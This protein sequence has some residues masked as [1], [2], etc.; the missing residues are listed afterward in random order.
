MEIALRHL[1]G[2]R[3]GDLVELLEYAIKRPD[4]RSGKILAP[5]TSSTSTLAEWTPLE[6]AQA[7]WR[8][9]EEGIADPQVSAGAHD[10]VR[11]VLQAAFRLPDDDVREA[12]GSSL[13]ERFKQLRVLRSVFGE[14]TTTQPMEI[15][16]KH[17]VQR[18][19]ERVRERLDELRSPDDWAHYRSGPLLITGTGRSRAGRRGPGSPV[20]FRP[21]SEG[22]QKLLINFLVVTVTMGGRVPIRRVSERIITAQEDGLAFYTTHAFSSESMIQSRSYVPT[23]ALWG[24][25]AEQ[26]IQNGLQLTRLWFPRPLR[27]GERAHFVTEAAHEPDEGDQVG[28]ANVEVDHYGIDP[29]R[30]HDDVLPV[31]GLTIRIG[32]D[33]RLL[34]AAAWWYAEQ[35][36]QE[37]YSEPPIG[38]LRRLDISHGNVV[39]TFEQ[40]CQPRENYGI[41]YRWD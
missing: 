37:R 38:S 32:F 15:S 40:P 17:G 3:H 24:C 7:V 18:L 12:W 16:W 1:G 20:V 41:A 9:I 36:E 2:R 10:R 23:R 4:D 8:I 19:A 33:D 28:W 34:P 21:P 26:V 6:R 25:R 11:R 5:L 29:G 13:T 27:A 39:K 35:N 22:A 31:S 30:V 14:A